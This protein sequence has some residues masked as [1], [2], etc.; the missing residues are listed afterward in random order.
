MNVTWKY[1]FRQ[2]PTLRHKVAFTQRQI[3]LTFCET[4]PDLIHKV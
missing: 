4:T 1:K 2:Y 3:Y